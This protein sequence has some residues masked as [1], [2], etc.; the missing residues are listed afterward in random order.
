MHNKYKKLRN[1]VNSQIRTDNERIKNETNENEHWKIG[2]EITKPQN[3]SS[4]H[5]PKRKLV[6]DLKMSQ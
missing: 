5:N 6:K 3:E 4:C 2:G 1:K